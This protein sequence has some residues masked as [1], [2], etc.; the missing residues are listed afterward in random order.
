MNFISFSMTQACTEFISLFGHNQLNTVEWFINYV[1]TANWAHS[2]SG[3]S[4]GTLFSQS[5]SAGQCPESIIT[6]RKTVLNSQQIKWSHRSRYCHFFMRFVCDVKLG[7]SLTHRFYYFTHCMGWSH[8]NLH[9]IVQFF[10]LFCI[11]NLVYWGHCR[12]KKKKNWVEGV[13]NIHRGEKTQFPRL[14]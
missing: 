6:A 5:R 11:F 13:G 10:F 12:L 1:Y 3:S 7:M 14:K 8:E 2:Q 9:Q 4:S